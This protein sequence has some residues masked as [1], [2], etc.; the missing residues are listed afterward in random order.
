MNKKKDFTAEGA[1]SAE[2]IN[3]DLAADYADYADIFRRECAIKNLSA[4]SAFSAV[5]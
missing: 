5:N 3:K 1:E 4:F 2:K